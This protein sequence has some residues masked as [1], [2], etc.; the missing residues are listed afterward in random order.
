MKTQTTNNRVQS[1]GWSTG[2][3][4]EKKRTSINLDSDIGR[5]IEMRSKKQDYSF[6]ELSITVYVNILVWSLSEVI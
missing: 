5:M 2:L 4:K 1:N 3:L 6:Q